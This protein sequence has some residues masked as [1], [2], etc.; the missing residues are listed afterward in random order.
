[1]GASQQVDISVVVAAYNVAE[2]VGQ[3]L[4]SLLA[5][6]GVGLEVIV[7]D[8]AS[9]DA[10]A[11]TVSARFGAAPNVKLLRLGINRGPSHAR[12]MAI[13][14]ATGQWIA[15][16]DA[17]DWCA[18]VRFRALLELAHRFDA[19]VVSDD[20]HVVEDGFR[21]PWSTI[22]RVNRWRQRVSEPVSFE[23]FVR[24]RHIVKPLIKRSFLQAHH[25]RFNE[26][27][28]HGED[29]LLLSELLLA[30]AR[31]HMSPVPMYYYRIRQGSITNTGEFAHGNLRSLERLL[32]LDVVKNNPRFTSLC[33]EALRHA[34][35]RERVR[36]TRLALRNL[37]L[38]ALR[39]AA[40]GDASLFWSILRH[41][42]ALAPLRVRRRLHR[43]RFG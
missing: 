30:G 43:I 39:H 32:E 6:T 31:W 20:Q 33:E 40:A 36:Q 28:R 27:V 9:S 15:W 7:V 4:E 22:N 38:A 37:D 10:T 34:A 16:V 5:C 41:E 13:T 1:M 29:F 21:Q 12:N 3:C 35:R 25:L 19:D 2:Y 26:E 24:S 14:A 42:A 23:R 17:D 18:P 8:D 11:D